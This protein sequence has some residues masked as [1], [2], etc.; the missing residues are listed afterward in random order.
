MPYCDVKLSS[1]LS[2]LKTKLYEYY[3]NKLNTIFDIDKPRTWKTLCSIA[4]NV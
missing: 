3:K 1:S 4:I 2:I